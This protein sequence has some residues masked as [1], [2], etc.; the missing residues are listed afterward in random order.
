[1]VIG[2]IV[3]FCILVLIDLPVLLKTNNRK[4]TAVIYIFL[5]ALGFTIGLLQVLGNP[6]PS[7]SRIIENI[8]KSIS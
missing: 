2:L 1:M 3:I 6:P 8:I 5:M 4:K 7:P